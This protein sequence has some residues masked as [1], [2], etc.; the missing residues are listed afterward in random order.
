MTDE[1]QSYRDRINQ[2][3]QLH[4]DQASSEKLLQAMQY[5][6]FNGGKRIRPL[7]V[8]LTTEAFDSPILLA[9]KTA[10][11]I[12]FIHCYSLIH[13]DL[14]AMDDDSLRRG[15]PTVHIKFDE[16]TAILA[17]DAF[18]SLAF[19]LIAS[20]DQLTPEIR[21][22]L[23]RSI[24]HAAGANGMVA[25]QMIDIES[26]G[27]SISAD[28]LEL[29]HNR[30]TGD[31]ISASVMSGAIISGASPEMRTNIQIFGSALGLAF[32]VKDDILDETGDTS[33]MGKQRGSDAVRNKTTFVS[34]HGLNAA[35]N[36]LEELSLKAIK[37]L[38]PLG[39]SGA[40]LI[41]LVNFNANRDH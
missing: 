27:Q 9:D 22:D 31:L 11:A 8:Y 40:H 19:D 33:R 39:E 13:D 7:L 25:G 15:K 14:P 20:D 4:L 16:A 6:V 23:V 26:E 28:E 12:E 2:Q 3:L 24:A 41:N 10:C 30:K 1:F 5:A 21:V 35:S 37:S 29:M 32:Q 17:A 38:K 34:I 18:Q 36:Y